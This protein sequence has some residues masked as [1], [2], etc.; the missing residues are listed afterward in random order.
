[1]H[2]LTKLIKT[3]KTRKCG[4]FADKHGIVVV[5]TGQENVIK[6]LKITKNTVFPDLSAPNPY[7]L[8][9]DSDHFAV[10]TSHTGQRRGFGAE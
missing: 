7:S 8:T 9:S 1:M 5:L 6:S 4:G 2:F 10:L 3:E